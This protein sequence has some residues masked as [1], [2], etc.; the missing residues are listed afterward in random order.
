MAS[1]NTS[2]PLVSVSRCFKKRLI[3]VRCLLAYIERVIF[4]R[5]TGRLSTVIILTSPPVSSFT[6][7]AKETIARAM[8]AG[9]LSTVISLPPI[10]RK[11]RSGL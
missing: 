11:V 8:S 9:R 7:F 10:K 3:E 1:E 6:L 5:G 4:V 2:L